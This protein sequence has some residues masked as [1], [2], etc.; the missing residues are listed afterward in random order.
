MD[1]LM[2]YIKKKYESA[3]LNTFEI[4]NILCRIPTQ[5][6]ICRPAH[7]VIHFLSAQIINSF[8]WKHA[9]SKIS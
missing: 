6:W 5:P 7:I 8:N 4:C 2:K 9:A 1:H 3:K